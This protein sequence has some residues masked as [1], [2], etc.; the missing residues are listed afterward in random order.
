[1]EAI[2]GG[3]LLSASMEMLVKKVVSGEFLDL[4]RRTKL[5]VDLL[6]KLEI[7][8]LSLQ[9]V[10]HDAEDKQIANPAVK[11]CLEMLQDAVFEADD[12]FD[13][14]NTE[15][16]RCQ[17]EGGQVLNKFLSYFKRFN[18]KI[19]SKLQKLFGRLEHLKNQ[20]L[21]LKEGD[22]NCVWNA[23]PTSPF[24]GD[25]SAIYGKDDDRK[26]LKGFLLLEDGCFLC[27][28]GF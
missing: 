19:N 10:L 6:E 7:T 18:K 8:L 11:K 28:C 25:E 1:M 24:L 4:F 16:L 9:S 5:D 13:E 22:S 17:A 15:A 27:V 26:K 2:V 3:A 23:T 20:N 14:L 12:L 21:G